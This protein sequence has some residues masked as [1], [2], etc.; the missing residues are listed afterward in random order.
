MSWDHV[1]DVLQATVLGGS[2]LAAV[3][4][5]LLAGAVSFASPCVLPLIPGY[6]GYLGGMGGTLGQGTAPGGEAVRTV[7]ASRARTGQGRLLVGVLLFVLGFSS[8]FVLLGVVFGWLGVALAPWLD[9]VTR[10]LG[11][12]VILMGLAFMGAVPVLQRDRRLQV[13]PRAGLWGAPLLG[14]VFGLGWAPCMGPTLSAV[15]L[16]SLDGGDPARGALLAAAYCLGLGVPF[17]MIAL[18]YSRTTRAM[19]FLRRHRLTIM[20]IGGAMLIVVGATMV[21]GLWG[22]FAG[23]VQGLVAGFVTVV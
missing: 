5:A 11:A 1:T 19:G 4:V 7:H 9:V 16:L 6:V 17:L 12:V 14:V 22:Q 21:T 3:L 8:V 18:L 10:V 20:R 23:W 13:S 15:L 2:L